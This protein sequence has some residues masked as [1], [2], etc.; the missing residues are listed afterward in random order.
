MRTLGLAA[1]SVVKQALHAKET[2]HSSFGQKPNQPEF[3]LV[4]A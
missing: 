4:G 2:Q 1:A 3:R